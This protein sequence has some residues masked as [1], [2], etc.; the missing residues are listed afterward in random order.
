MRNSSFINCFIIAKQ[1]SFYG[2]PDISGTIIG[3]DHDAEYI[4]RLLHTHWKVGIIGKAGIGKTTLAIK[5]AHSCHVQNI[6]NHIV[7][8][9]METEETAKHDFHVLYKILYEESD[10]TNITKVIRAEYN[11]H[12]TN[13]IKEIHAQY[14]ECKTLF[15][16]D[17]V[18]S[19]VNIRKYLFPQFRNISI[20]TTSQLE[21]NLS[22]FYIYS[23]NMFETI[24]SI[25]LDHTSVN[26]LPDKSSNHS[27]AL[28]VL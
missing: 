11:T 27:L 25:E 8:I 17:N 22:M 16:Y 4:I 9:N 15:I 1:A 20:L 18:N 12:N 5:I 2:V 24:E 28:Q 7:W 6:F 10:N 26:E 13:I 21:D 14:N 3:R 19:A 23:L